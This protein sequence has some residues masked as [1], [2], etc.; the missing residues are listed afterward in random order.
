MI[1]SATAADPL[2]ASRS[3]VHTPSSGDLRETLVAPMLPLPP[4]SGGDQKFVVE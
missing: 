3:S 2:S 4:E 1:P